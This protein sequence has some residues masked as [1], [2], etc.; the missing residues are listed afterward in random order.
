MASLSSDYVPQGKVTFKNSGTKFLMTVNENFNTELG[1]WYTFENDFVD[2]ITKH[3]Y[4]FLLAMEYVS[5]IADIWGSEHYPAY[6]FQDK[7]G[8]YSFIFFSPTDK[9]H[10]PQ[11]VILD[12]NGED[13]LRTG[14]YSTPPNIYG[15]ELE[16]F[17]FMNHEEKRA[18]IGFA[19][20]YNLAESEYRE[21]TYLYFAS[22]IVSNTGLYEHRAYEIFNGST[23]DST[24]PY[25]PDPEPPAP[26]PDPDPPSEPI[27]I[28]DLPDISATDTGFLT[29]Y[30]PTA[31]QLK[32][33]ANYMWSD[34][35]SLD[36]LKKIFADPMDTI[37]GC[38][39]VPCDVPSGGTREVTVGNIGTGVNMIVATSQYAKVKCGSVKIPKHWDGYMDYSP[40]TKLQI[41][42]PYIGFRD[43]NID[44]CMGKTLGV[45][46]HI[47]CLTGSCTAFVTCNNSVFYE[48]SGQCSTLVPFT[49]S[50]WNSVI[51]S[52]VG[53][54]ST[55]AMGV[56]SV[57]TAP[58]ASAAMRAGTMAT[59]SAGASTVNAVVNGK[60]TINKS[61]ALGGGAGILGN[62][63]PFICLIRPNQCV[64]ANQNKFTGYPSYRTVSLGS[65]SGFTIVEDVHLEN[66]TA[67]D[68]E[69]MEIE[70]KLKSGVI[71]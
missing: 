64:P 67:T 59:A 44:E 58:T 14:L 7:I 49:G 62:Q 19:G 42:L 68:A 47:D 46:Y 13:Y 9:T 55:V 11:L 32:S 30:N 56:A 45:E 48:Y 50:N 31:T 61:S 4:N 35:F 17:I 2:C 69:K 57:G 29:L 21:H 10:T 41:F 5:D 33:L 43:L 28:P 53:V 63:K 24:D 70:N 60:E 54:A 22:Y 16:L 6:V 65:I 20:R 3:G 40:Y 26:N 52:A 66:L 51:Q 27:P 1:Y 38:A 23:D 8:D 18:V 37:I 34:L 15:D 36:T 71:L 12:K 25:D 39:I